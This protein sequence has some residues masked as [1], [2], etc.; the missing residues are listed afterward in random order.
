VLVFHKNFKSANLS[1][2]T[3]LI[4]PLCSLGRAEVGRKRDAKIHARL[5][6]GFA[7]RPDVRVVSNLNGPI[8][9]VKEGVNVWEARVWGVF[10]EFANIPEQPVRRG[11]RTTNAAHTC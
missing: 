8:G 11:I 10:L 7:A 6:K 4:C 5:D 9:A 2:K 3:H 1:R